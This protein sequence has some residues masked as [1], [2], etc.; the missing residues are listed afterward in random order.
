[1]A[2]TISN[3]YREMA[4][5]AM[6]LNITEDE[7]FVL[8]PS[9]RNNKSFY[10]VDMDEATTQPTSCKCP[11]FCRWNHCKHCTIVA[12]A[13]A[14]YVVATPAEEPKIT[15]IEAGQWYI[16][17]KNTQVWRTEDGVWMAVG[18]TAN[19][20]ELVEAHIAKQQAV[21][22]A[23]RIVAQPATEARKV[24]SLVAAK[25]AEAARIIA[26]GTYTP[27]A[28][29]T[30]VLKD[31]EQTTVKENVSVNMLNAALTKNQGFCMMR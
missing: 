11:G 17:N 10:R 28:V 24:S 26:S 20:I 12:E 6:S 1:M 8:I 29:A 19:A 7:M 2:A 14:G 27:N 5:Q 13:F 9:E 4:V 16:L 3:E 31:D 15:E 25:V 30:K 23:E 21:A 18:P 22:E